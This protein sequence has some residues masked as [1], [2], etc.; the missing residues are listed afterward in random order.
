M[1][2]H[3]RGNFTV[4]W[5]RP[6]IRAEAP[7]VLIDLQPLV[8]ETPFR[9]PAVRYPARWPGNPE[10][11]FGPPKK[12]SQPARPG[13]SNIEVTWSE[14]AMEK[15]NRSGTHT[16]SLGQYGDAQLISADQEKRVGVMP[17]LPESTILRGGQAPSRLSITPTQMAPSSSLKRDRGSVPP[18]LIDRMPVNVGFV[19]TSD[20]APSSPKPQRRLMVPAAM[21]AAGQPVHYTPP[22]AQT[23]PPPP[24]QSTPQRHDANISRGFPVPPPPGPSRGS[25]YGGELGVEVVEHY[26]YP[27]PSPAKPI[28]NAKTPAP[29]PA[30][31]P[32]SS[33]TTNKFPRTPPSTP[34]FVPLTPPRTPEES[35]NNGYSSPR[36]RLLTEA[37]PS[38]TPPPPPPQL[39]SG[40]AGRT[41]TPVQGSPT[42]DGA[43]GG[44]GGGGRLSPPLGV[45]GGGRLS[46]GPGRRTP[47]LPP[48]TAQELQ[49]PDP[50]PPE[51]P[52]PII[53]NAPPPNTASNHHQQH[54]NQAFTSNAATGS[55]SPYLSPLAVPQQGPT[56]YVSYAPRTSF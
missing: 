12:E 4:T 51:A 3:E 19:S 13:S 56:Y 30:K 37:S 53:A 6:L 29:S 47:P 36:E 43:A 31:P 35:F 16:A 21:V 55:P 54:R 14:A 22:P 25:M 49:Y 26:P 28:A 17:F 41:L 5:V 40:G 7:M 18:G 44:G 48:R 33:L 42:I 50:P 15:T 9:R 45:G 39:Q 34:G 10:K 24:P 52:T 11:S 23:L 20:L 32:A 46:P 1:T 27:A 2:E 38:R 8:D